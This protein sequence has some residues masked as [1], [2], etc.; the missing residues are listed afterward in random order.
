MQKLFIPVVCV[1]ALLAGCDKTLIDNPG[2]Y[3]KVYMPQAAE[4]PAARALAMED[5]LQPLPFGAVFG[6]VEG[7]QQPVTVK[8]K[9][10]MALVD[11]FNKANNT[12]WQPM[13]AGSWSL[14]AEEAV[15]ATGNPSSNTLQLKVKTVGGLPIKTQYLL[16]VTITSLSPAIAVNEKL[17]T[18]YFLISADYRDFNRST[19]KVVGE[20]SSESPNTGDK[21]WDNNIAT[22]WHTA[23]KTTKPAHPHWLTVDMGSEQSVHGFYTLPAAVATGNPENI[24]ME[25]SVD[26]ASWTDAGSFSF[27]NLFSRQNMYLATT[28]KARYFRINVLSSF[29]ATHFTHVGEFGA[30]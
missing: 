3:T 27:I 13:P 25:I 1:A 16:P 15:I 17:R 26:G 24:K 11:S 18:T 28:M 19:W 29:S 12:S 14:S 2:Q 30:F 10:D 22:S 9:V 8:F 5:T 4:Y 21:I 6:G 7:Q 23:W 20:S